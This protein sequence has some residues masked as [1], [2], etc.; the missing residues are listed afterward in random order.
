M[1][2]INIWQEDGEMAGKR[3]TVAKKWQ[4]GG[5][6]IKETTRN[7]ERQPLGIIVFSVTS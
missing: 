3:Q 6:D 7:C 5:S 1:S 4:E 2:K